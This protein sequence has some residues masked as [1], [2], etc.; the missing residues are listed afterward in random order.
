[1][2]EDTLGVL[3]GAQLGA[4]G[5]IVVVAAEIAVGLGTHHQLDGSCLAQAEAFE[6]QGGDFVQVFFVSH[7]PLRLG[8]EAGRRI[9]SASQAARIMAFASFRPSTCPFAFSRPP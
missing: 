7:G 3:L 6:N 1:L 4:D 9:C 8:A 2:L 5:R